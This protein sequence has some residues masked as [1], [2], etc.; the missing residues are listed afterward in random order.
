MAGLG[1]YEFQ[2]PGETPA[3][4][5]YGRGGMLRVAVLGLV[6]V[7]LVIAAGIYFVLHRRPVPS[8]APAQPAA[9][10]A[11]TPAAP[12]EDIEKIDLPPLDDSDALVRQRVGLLS[13]HPLVA[14][15]LGTNG[16]ARNF[17]VVV[18]NISH[19]MNPSSHLRILKPAGEFRVVARGATTVIDPRGYERFNPIRQAAA[20]FDAHA[21]GRLYLAFRPLLQ[22]A[23][24]E[25][26]NQ[27]PFDRAVERSIVS[28]L[29]VPAIDGDVRVQQGEG[30]GYEYADARLES[31]SG[32]QKQ[33]LR[34]GPDNIRIIQAQLRTFA[35]AIGLPS[36]RVN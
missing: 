3:Q 36:S 17:V 16:L 1:D 13:S 18:D 20:S 4:G 7:G 33:L 15:W 10:V 14:K 2:P 8:G 34:M 11:Q 5:A 31:L 27:E 19:G 21:A 30:I 22:T 26:G 9:S 23:Y 12:A 28:L 29:A 6:V 32:A 24:D 35:A 25:L